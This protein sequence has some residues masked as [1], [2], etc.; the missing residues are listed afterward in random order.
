MV[1]L[2]HALTG[3]IVLRG[4]LRAAWGPNRC[5][6]GDPRR[7]EEGGHPDSQALKVERVVAAVLC[8]AR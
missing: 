4:R 2:S 3:Q 1:W 7:D 8:V 6:L 5:V